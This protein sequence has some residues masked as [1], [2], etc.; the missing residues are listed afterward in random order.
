MKKRN[1]ITL[2]SLSLFPPFL[3]SGTFSIRK[4]EEDR[5]E[6]NFKDEAVTKNYERFK[7]T[8][9]VVPFKFYD[10]D[11]VI[12]NKPRIISKEYKIDES[13]IKVFVDKEKKNYEVDLGIFEYDYPVDVLI[14][15]NFDLI[16]DVPN[17]TLA[18][19]KEQNGVVRT[20]IE[21]SKEE[22]IS[23]PDL[24]EVID[25]KK[26]SKVSRLNLS[27]QL[28]EK[29]TK[30]LRKQ[31]VAIK[32]DKAKLQNNFRKAFTKFKSTSWASRTEEETRAKN[33]LENQKNQIKEKKNK[34]KNLEKELDADSIKTFVLKTSW[35]DDAT[36]KNFTFKQTFK[37]SSN[38]FNFQSRFWEDEKG[39]YFEKQT[40]WFDTSRFQEPFPI[41]MPFL[42]EP[43]NQ[44]NDK[45][46]GFFVESIYS[47]RFY[48]PELDFNNNELYFYD[49]TEI[50]DNGFGKY[51]W[52]E[53]KPYNQ[54]ELER[55]FNESRN[56]RF[57]GALKSVL[58]IGIK[59]KK[60][61]QTKWVLL[62]LLPP[63]I[64]D[65]DKSNRFWKK[66]D[67]ESMIA[68]NKK[69]IERLKT[70]IKDKE[71][72]DNLKKKIEYSIKNLEEKNQYLNRNLDFLD[73]LNPF[74]EYISEINEN[75]TNKPNYKELAN[76]LSQSLY[77]LKDPILDAN[78]N[79]EIH[80]KSSFFHFLQ[81]TKQIAINDLASLNYHDIY[82]LFQ[83][84]LTH[85][86][87][88]WTTYSPLKALE[89]SFD[90]EKL[91][92]TITS[93]SSLEK[94]K[95]DN[96]LFFKDF[97][98]ITSKQQKNISPD[99]VLKTI[100]SLELDFNEASK[101]LMIT[102]KQKSNLNKEYLFSNT[103]F[104]LDLKEKKDIT[105][106]FLK[107]KI[108]INQKKLK[109]DIKSL[110]RNQFIKYVEKNPNFIIENKDKYIE[111]VSFSKE[112]GFDDFLEKE[113]KEAKVIYDWE[114]FNSSNGKDLVFRVKSEHYDFGSFEIKDLVF[115]GDLFQ[116]EK[117]D[118]LDNDKKVFEINLYD[119]LKKYSS[120][121][122]NTLSI[123]SLKEIIK[124]KLEDWFK[125]IPWLQEVSY[126]L[127]DFKSNLEDVIQ[128]TNIKKLMSNQSSI[129]QKQSDF[130]EISLT[131][132][133]SA[134]DENKSKKEL[135]FRFTNI[136]PFDFK[137]LKLN[138]I[139]LK[140]DTLFSTNTSAFEYEMWYKEIIAEIKKNITL[141]L[142]NQF[143]TN[144]D[145]FGSKTTIEDFL[146]T[147]KENNE[148]LFTFEFIP[149]FWIK[150]SVDSLNLNEGE[151][152]E[153]LD[154]YLES[155]FYALRKINLGINVPS[156]LKQ[157][158]LNAEEFNISIQNN[159]SS[160]RVIDFSILREE[161]NKSLENKY[162]NWKENLNT[163]YK[164]DFD[165]I[166]KTLDVPIKENYN[167]EY[168]LNPPKIT[169]KDIFADS[170]AALKQK[171]DKNLLELTNKLRNKVFD[172][173]N[174]LVE[175]AKSTF[176]L[177]G[178][179][180][181]DVIKNKISNYMKL[182]NPSYD[183]SFFDVDDFISANKSYAFDAYQ[184]FSFLLPNV[185]FTNLKSLESLSLDKLK[186]INKEINI[187]PSKDEAGQPKWGINSFKTTLDINFNKDTIFDLLW[188]KYVLDLEK[189]SLGFFEL[190]KVLKD[191][192][193]KKY[194]LSL[195][196]D[197]EEIINPEDS[198]DDTNTHSNSNNKSNK[199][200]TFNVKEHLWWIIPLA[201]IVPLGAIL[202]PILIIRLK[203]SKKALADSEVEVIN[204]SKENKKNSKKSKNN[205]ILISLLK[206][207]NNKNTKESKE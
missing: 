7:K 19:L 117:P 113:F 140:I 134:L 34:E 162:P 42:L 65:N 124:K 8:I 182:I 189:S 62:Q 31:L 144:K 160:S 205:D 123:E 30:E 149:S 21:P 121:I 119:E 126:N 2:L 37:L 152:Q 104:T 141:E 163:K 73:L 125:E 159:S 50:K 72:P 97:V 179:Y 198:P 204:K 54:T 207:K 4:A 81:K 127:S 39:S 168:F 188:M 64:D 49:L 195:S 175:L 55:I 38:S 29:E 51:K 177:Y 185:D 114:T 190:P 184:V 131:L 145:I 99:E 100:E 11:S 89:V 20:D 191:K 153:I 12:E 203:R 167:D 41:N 107:S 27:P 150:K 32:K 109:E 102:F 33:D 186:D 143:K 26:S 93:S 164:D 96:S 43:K 173:S 138:D 192:V 69:E 201:W 40:L 137:S 199:D 98:K 5:Q 24:A 66:L 183:K 111:N 56:A 87:N 58:L 142:I 103:E 154:K 47:D 17:V 60:T 52:P 116:N 85:L 133:A 112:N 14:H 15:Y 101:H 92:N 171:F 130:V 94:Y 77:R 146:K 139:S 166:A 176:E 135:F 22:K 120:S 200:K 76:L 45:N 83:E 170:S 118:Y 1:L 10:N 165:D 44:Q 155:L 13:K 82:I 202:L 53:K 161:I 9:S 115:L 122:I 79:L 71:K 68:E 174:F 156:Y 74:I 63:L 128:D 151:R 16:S 67:F 90:Y 35:T 59:N 157:Y 46:I 36:R 180:I 129:K 86:A 172:N 206:P 136:Q 194:E 3:V 105:F 158:Y 88:K 70:L 23:L 178:A 197:I 48:I 108:E 91:A 84:Y 18:T 148:Q 181:N 196:D 25:E 57:I 80:P 6:V 132:D 78:R 28:N 110:S 187:V 169:I 75:G 106:E 193:Y 95:K 61:N 147:D